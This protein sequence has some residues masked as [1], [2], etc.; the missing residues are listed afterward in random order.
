M[1]HRKRD[2]LADLRKSVGVE[3]LTK[4]CSGQG[5]SVSMAGVPLTR[6]VVDADSAFPAHG[7]QGGR[8]DRVLFLVHGSRETLVAAPIEL[9]SGSVDVSKAF[10]QLRQ[11]I[12]FVHRMLPEDENPLCRPLLV[13]GSGMH[14][15]DWKR[16]NRAKIQFR[17]RELT[18]KTARCGRLKNLAR[19]LDLE[20]SPSRNGR[21]VGTP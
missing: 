19:A 5:C 12:E 1:A 6:I 3:N 16:L 10:E 13:H 9:K 11:G 8:C 17:D 4:S 2:I 21:P 18:I 15:K 20:A 7:I 14:P